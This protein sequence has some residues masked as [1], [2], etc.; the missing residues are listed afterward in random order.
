[1]KRKQREN[2][3]VL[4]VAMIAMLLLVVAI[5]LTVDL[6]TTVRSKIKIQAAADAAALT[7]AEWQM[8]SLNLVGDIN[9]IKATTLLYNYSTNTDEDEQ[10]VDADQ[11]LS[12]LQFRIATIGP[13][14]GYGAAQQAA[15][16][17]SITVNDDEKVRLAYEISAI[18]TATDRDTVDA[19][20]A[21]NNC[22]GD[23]RTPYADQLLQS[24]YANGPAASMLPDLVVEP[25]WL[26][27][28]ETLLAVLSSNF[29]RLHGILNMDDSYWLS[30]WQ[31]S[32]KVYPHNKAGQSSALSLELQIPNT[33]L[34]SSTSSTIK[35]ELTVLAAQNGWTVN[36][37][38]DKVHFAAYNSNWSDTPDDHWNNSYSDSHY[39]SG[40][41]RRDLLDAAKCGGAISPAVC[42]QDFALLMN[43]K[44][45][46]A[47]TST[48]DLLGAGSEGSS[49]GAL[50]VRNF[51]TAKHSK[52]A[53]LTITHY[54]SSGDAIRRTVHTT[55]YAAAK[56]FADKLQPQSLTIVLP[57]FTK[58]ALV[59]FRMYTTNIKSRSPRYEA[60]LIWLAQ[61]GSQ[62]TDIENL[63]SSLTVPSAFSQ[64]ITAL[65]ILCSSELNYKYPV[66]DAD[67]NNVTDSTGAVI[68][69]EVDFRDYGRDWLNDHSCPSHSG[70]GSVDI[71]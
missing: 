70:D 53:A 26:G 13:L 40:I 10:V 69:T 46:N 2:G 25:S 56:P 62:I 61:N 63:P 18:D 50:S 5:L 1:M 34:S 55:A 15:K 14:I 8:K 9:L 19:N 59:P 33:A 47:H 11:S 71:M 30:G 12:N 57:I 60:F 42:Q 23:W 45:T 68:Y 35:T 20:L 27:N 58:V 24:I 67:G 17:N 64:Y 41:L 21:T 48:G 66:K 28:E 31:Q 16:N 44:P 22:W 39:T 6:Q 3:Y 32:V 4:I 36:N 52:P 29:C 37:V 43:F 54:D 7:G 49:Y 51:F 65:Q 38:L